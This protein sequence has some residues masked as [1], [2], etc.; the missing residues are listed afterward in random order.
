L[1]VQQS[2]L[3]TFA[4]ADLESD[5]DLMRIAQDDARLILETEPELDGKR[6]TALRVLLYLQDRDAAIQYLGGG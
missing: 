3:P 4:I 1:G 6:G 2:G 5:G